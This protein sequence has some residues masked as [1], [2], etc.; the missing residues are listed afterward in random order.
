MS[1]PNGLERGDADQSDAYADFRMRIARDGVWFHEG[2]PINRIKLAKLFSTILRREDDGQYWLVTPV[3]RGRIAVEDSPFVAVEMHREGAGDGQVLSFRTNL[4][5]RVTADAD[6]PIVMERSPFTGEI[7]PYVKME[8]GL[9]ARLSRPVYYDLAELSVPG[10]GD[11][12]AMG[13]W[14]KGSFFVL[15]DAADAGEGTTE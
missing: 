6:H 12:G 2:E 13:V 8:R 7:T 1:D 3:E 4:D 5:H 11:D 9:S 14:S 10:S 15:H